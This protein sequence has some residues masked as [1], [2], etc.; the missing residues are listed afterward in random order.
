MAK[1]PAGVT[2]DEEAQARVMP[3]AVMLRVGSVPWT[4]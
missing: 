1:G 3:P 2:R 4:P